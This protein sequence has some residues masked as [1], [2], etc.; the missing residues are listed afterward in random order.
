MLLW[1][2]WVVCLLI[3]PLSG[4]QGSALAEDFLAPEVAFKVTTAVRDVGCT[5]A[6]L[7]DVNIEVAPQYY[8]YAERFKVEP[9]AGLKDLKILQL[10]SGERK[11]DENLG[12]EIEALRGLLQFQLEYS[13]TEGSPKANLISQGCA[14][15]G[16]CYPPMTSEISF[17]PSSVQTAVNASSGES[18]DEASLLAQRLQS[19]PFWV[20]L[21][22]FFGLGL[23]L[24]FTPCTL[25]ML[26]I[27]ASLVVGSQ[28]GNSAGGHSAGGKKSRS[29]FLALLY[30]LG[31][32]LTYAVLGVVAGLS[33]QSLVIALQQPAVLWSF[34]AVLA[35]LGLALLMGFS[36]QMPSGM[37]AWIQTK[38]SGLKGGEYLPV[39]VM[40]IL[41]A[42][43][44][45]PC[46]APPLA[47]AL[48]FIGQTGNAALGGAALFLLSLG[49]GLPLV[50]LA[51]G[52]GA[53][54]PKAGY[55][56]SWVSVAFGYILI[57]VAVWTITPVT[58][59][60]VVMGMWVVLGCLVAASCF[61][62]VA[63]GQVKSMA[64]NTLFRGLGLLSGLLALVYL[65]GLL[66]GS[67]SLIS[68]L[69]RLNRADVASAVG[70]PVGSPNVFSVSREGLGFEPTGVADKNKKHAGPPFE[71]V[72]SE[73][74]LSVIAASKQPVL[75][76]FYA[77][78]C[79][80]CK[81]FELF[82]LTDKTV[83]DKLSGFRLVRVDVTAN[84]EADKALMKNFSLFGPPAL[85][86]FDVNGKEVKAQRVVGF[87][88]ANK[89]SETLTK[90]RLAIGV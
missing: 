5:Q 58:P 75:I 34:G 1:R 73:N 60:H 32:S 66:S 13:P 59:V 23:L 83:Q 57:A 22:V 21:P 15:A 79:V 55:W 45:G 74:V 76:D 69:E 51:G 84:N 72:L 49:M 30:V 19:Q 10:P 11:F 77:D 33:G 7:I 61:Q 47:G 42:L 12:M 68:P 70:E 67:Q 29:I 85:L 24:A 52:A 87:Q 3:L 39:L 41:S 36:L 48:L 53:A 80:S 38:A 9:V 20:V 28:G 46:V 63:S 88:N 40:G 90:V 56:M 8:L 62:G 14:D 25:P 6:C 86:F 54:L 17:A 64:A 35:G 82:T 31:M 26:P 27:V 89:F 71:P 4:W 2:M 81:E 18:L 44:L 78:W 16:L 43:L 50:L 37:Q 65:I